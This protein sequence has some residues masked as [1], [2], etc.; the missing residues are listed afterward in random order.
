MTRP[1][2][3]QPERFFEQ[4]VPVER[5]LGKRTRAVVRSV[6]AKRATSI[7]RP[8]RPGRYRPADYEQLPSWRNL[9]AAQVSVLHDI[10]T[11]PTSYWTG[12]PVFRRLPPRPGFV[13]QLVGSERE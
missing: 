12:N 9:T 2:T 10:L 3:R 4:P 5:K 11:D 8:C 6:S 1:G 7:R 13:F